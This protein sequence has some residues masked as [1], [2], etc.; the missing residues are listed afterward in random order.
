[1]CTPPAN[2]EGLNPIVQADAAAH[3][4]NG[5]SNV[6]DATSLTPGQLKQ[7]GEGLLT[8]YYNMISDKSL[9]SEFKGQVLSPAFQIVRSNGERMDNESFIPSTFTNHTFSNLSITAASPDSVVMTFAAALP[10]AHTNTTTFSSSNSPR[11]DVFTRNNITNQW[12][13]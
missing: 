10:G 11:L 9:F 1:M 5:F 4:N 12:Q 2:F 7:F 6:T 3:T 8:N 13:V